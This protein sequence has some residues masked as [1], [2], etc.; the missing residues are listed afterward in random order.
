MKMLIYLSTIMAILLISVKVYAIHET[1]PAETEIVPEE[2]SFKEMHNLHIMMKHGLVMV[3]QGSNLVMLADMKMSPGMDSATL[4]HGQKMI[5]SGKMVINR[6]LSGSEMDVLMKSYSK[7]PLMN[8]TH[9]LGKAMLKAVYILE[10]MKITGIDEAKKKTMHHIHMMINHTLQMG[11]EGSNLLMIGQMDMSKIVDAF[12]TEHG[13]QMLNSA[14]DLLSEVMEGKA[15]KDMHTR[16]IT[17]ETSND[18]ALAH[19]LAVAAT[20]V[21]DLQSK[22][23]DMR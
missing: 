15:M 17:Q 16:G 7:D 13:R 9:N 8:H 23:P 6:S 12:S 18:M 21:L 3:V 10:K 11:A 1:I 14:S 2:P 4:Q 22:M 5:K 19:E 20:K